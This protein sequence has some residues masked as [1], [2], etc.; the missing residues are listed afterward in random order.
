RER[1]VFTH[2]GWRKIGNEWIYLSG[3]MEGN[4][5]FEVNLGPELAR[6]KLPLIADDP[7]EAMR[8]S[9]KLLD[10]AP[11]KIT[12]PLFAACYRAPLVS[13]FPQDLSVW[14][15]GKTG[16]LKSSLAALFLS[17]FGD[18]DRIN[19]PGAWVSTANQL[20]RRAF[21]LKDSIFVID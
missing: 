18:F 12:A 6:Y 3:S 10:L 2:T 17:H 21:L 1:Y 16:S 4:Q 14:L 7:V 15:E 20:E 11:Y 8:A 13:A 5:D 19:L 9:L